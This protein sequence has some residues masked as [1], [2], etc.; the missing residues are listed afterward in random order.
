M[1]LFDRHPSA[2]RKTQGVANCQLARWQ[3]VGLFSQANRILGFPY[4]MRGRRAQQVN[5]PNGEPVLKEASRS[6]P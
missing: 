2:T 3:S 6:K 4:Q 1:I 5:Q